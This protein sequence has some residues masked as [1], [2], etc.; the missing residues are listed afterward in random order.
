MFC[1]A[2]DVGSG[3]GGVHNFY[4]FD[5]PEKTV[6]RT[7]FLSGVHPMPPTASKLPLSVAKVVAGLTHS[8]VLG[9]FKML[10]RAS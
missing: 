3:I 2:Q 10:F 8:G 1:L 4:M 7:P 9:V 5:H 6:V